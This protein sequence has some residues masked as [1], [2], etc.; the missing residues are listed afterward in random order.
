MKNKILIF[1]IKK[2]L[3]SILPNYIVVLS[4]PPRNIIISSLPFKFSFEVKIY[5]RKLSNSNKLTK[6]T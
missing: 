4:N 2:I 1:G 6:L 5:K 3:N